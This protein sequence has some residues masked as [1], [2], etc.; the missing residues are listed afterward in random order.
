MGCVKN[1]AVHNVLKWLVL[2]NAE[3]TCNEANIETAKFIKK[4]TKPCPKCGERI[5]KID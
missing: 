1:F 2:I 4:T 5:H 3:H